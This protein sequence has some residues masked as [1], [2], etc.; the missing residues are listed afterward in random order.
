[1]SRAEQNR[2]RHHERTV[3]QPLGHSQGR[4]APLRGGLGPPL[5]GPHGLGIQTVLVAT[6]RTTGAHDVGGTMSESTTDRFLLTIR[7]N[8]RHMRRTRGL[9][10]TQL[11]QACGRCQGW[12]SH[13]EHGDTDITL[14]DLHAIATALEVEAKT[15]LGT[16]KGW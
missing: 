12:A 13:I 1:M 4:C 7:Q 10:Q 9:T 11:A 5:T 14:R 3:A 2:R 16:N 8:I 15:L 6:E